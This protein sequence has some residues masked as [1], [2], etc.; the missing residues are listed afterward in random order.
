MPV[1]TAHSDAASL[2]FITFTCFNWLPLFQLTN[3]YDLVYKWFNY[4]KDQKHIS[5]TAFV[6]MPNHLH[7]LLFFPSKGYSL[8]TIIANSKRF[9]AYEMVKRLREMNRIDILNQ[10]TNALTENE[11]KKDQQHK[12]SRTVL[13]LN[14]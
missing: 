4:L 5:T 8:N 1:R 7:C 6:I 11:K 10:M 2:Y 14:Q 13:M 3:S 9:I 12:V